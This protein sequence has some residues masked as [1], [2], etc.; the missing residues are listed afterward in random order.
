MI[1]ASLYSVIWAR[2]NNQHDKTSEP[3]DFP[4]VHVDVAFMFGESVKTGAMVAWR[5]KRQEVE[6]IYCTRCPF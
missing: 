6:K 1:T 4:N 5:W 3:Y 2:Q